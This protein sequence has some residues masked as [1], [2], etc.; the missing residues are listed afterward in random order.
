MPP[1][2]LLQQ[3]VRAAIARLDADG[4]PLPD[5]LKALARDPAE[6]GVAEKERTQ[7]RLAALVRRLLRGQQQRLLDALA[8]RPPPRA[9][10][11]A[12]EDWL[13]YNLGGWLDD[14]EIPSALLLLLTDAVEG[15]VRL[16]DMGILDTTL[17]N[18]NAQRWARERAPE[19]LGQVN[20][21]TRQAVLE[22]VQAFIET[23]GYTVA[24]VARELDGV[25]GV[26]RAERVAV[27]EITGAY[28]EGQLLAG[29]ELA[30]TY[31]DVRVIKTWF[32]NNDSRVCP[33]CGPLHG[34]AVDIDSGWGADGSDDPEG[35]QG[36]PLHPNCRCWLG[37][38]TKIK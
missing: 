37:T 21:T 15:G 7:K 30:S 36:P 8:T 17:V 23:P 14:D 29:R 22:Q 25:F 18:R 26:E 5:D 32:T 10:K 24:D 34:M 38:R 33:L 9:Q 6:P 27:T 20:D 11:N 3:A 19:L 12:A 1:H 16:G 2:R 35:V 31:P 13:D 4:L 28:A